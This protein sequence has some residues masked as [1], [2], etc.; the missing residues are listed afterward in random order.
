MT[1]GCVCVCVCVCTGMDEIV[2][3]CTGMEEIRPTFG[4]LAKWCC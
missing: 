3:V 4:E 2:C 1:E